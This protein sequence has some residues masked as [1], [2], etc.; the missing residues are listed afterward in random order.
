MLISLNTEDEFN[1]TDRRVLKALLGEDNISVVVNTT[2]VNQ[3][4]Q[5]LSAALDELEESAVTEVED[6]EPTA[7]N[8]C[9]ICGEVFSSPRG[10]KSHITRSHKD[11]PKPAGFS[12]VKDVEEDEP[13]NEPEAE[14]AQVPGDEVEIDLTVLREQAVKTATEMV[15]A[16]K[17]A[18]VRKVLNEIGVRRVS[19]IDDAD[20]QRFLSSVA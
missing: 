20:L 9:E 12:V 8:G 6:N 1:E 18:D 13:S 19:E 5:A 10:L 15:A 7:E 14:V 11:V 2:T 3:Q 16:G 4:A 17:A